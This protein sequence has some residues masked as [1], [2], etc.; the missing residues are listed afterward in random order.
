MTREESEWVLL[1]ECY[2]VAELHTL[3]ATL[4]AHG[5]PCRI[6]G[7]HT[8]GV[9]GAI[10]GAMAR[11]RVL[12]P[13]RALAAARELAEDIVG[14]FDE[15][16]ALADADADASP[17]RKAAE[18]RAT[19]DAEPPAPRRKSYAVL[20]AAAVL[21]LT[22]LPLAGLAHLYVHR[23][24]RGGILLLVSVF[25][26]AASLRGAWWGSLVLNLAWVADFIGGAVGIAA[27]NRRLE[28]L[29]PAP[30][31]EPPDA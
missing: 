9:F 19:D 17:F 23:N 31:P 24:R 20:L 16:P 28:Q 14:P 8:H 26:L 30:E 21:M 10:H 25:S 18:L 13:R 27:H 5:V 22:A 29:P 1:V 15:R 3:R 7:E 11:S 6:H 12:V 4:E 2:N